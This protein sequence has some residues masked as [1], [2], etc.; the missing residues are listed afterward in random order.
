VASENDRSVIERSIV[1]L[2]GKCKRCQPM[3]LSRLLTPR[4][5]Y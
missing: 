2:K 5:C 4:R 1:S 3:S